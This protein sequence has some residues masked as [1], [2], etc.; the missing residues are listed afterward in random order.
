LRSRKQIISWAFA[1]SGKSASLASE[2]YL[3]GHARGFAARRDQRLLDAL[4][5]LGKDTRAEGGAR[6]S[7]TYD[8]RLPCV[9]NWLEIAGTVTTVLG[10]WLTTRR[11]LWCWPVVLAADVVYLIVFYRAQLLSDALLQIFFVAF[12]LYGWWHW[13]R[14]SARRGRQCA[15]FHWPC[16]PG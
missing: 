1:F 12:T 14:G 7:W 13:W 11:T 15:W 16:E 2:G 9:A 8:R 6:M 5:R 3:V 10:I 4:R